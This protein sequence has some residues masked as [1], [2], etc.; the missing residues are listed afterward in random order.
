MHDL[1]LIHS[2]YHYKE[3]N[4]KNIFTKL[5]INFLSKKKKSLF[6]KK[7]IIV[8]TSEWSRKKINK[9]YQSVCK[10][11]HKIPCGID[12]TKWF[13]I[14]KKIAKKTLGLKNKPT[15]LFIAFGVNNSRKGFNYLNQSLKFI[16]YDYELLIVGDEKPFNIVDKDYRFIHSPK[17]IKLRR[18]IYNSADLLVAPSIQE[19]FG[20]VCLEAAACNTP[21]VIF[22]DNGLEDLIDH[23]INGYIVKKKNIHDLGRGINWILHSI[24]IKPK[25]FNLCRKK[26]IKKYNI[27]NLANNFILFYKKLF[28]KNINFQKNKI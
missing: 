19:A 3:N 7:I 14:N 18:L 16:K 25:R 21:S 13:P 5:L 27:K 1:W 4:K 15:I 10:K 22:D 24:K 17:D 28:N 23:K 6:K 2:Y 8:P 20:L 26:V 9:K 11:Y 12:F